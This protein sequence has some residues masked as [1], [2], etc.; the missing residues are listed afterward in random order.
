MPDPSRTLEVLV[1]DDNPGDVKLIREGLKRSSIKLPL[2]IQIA[3]DGEQAL[4]L[5][6]RDNYQPDMIL[7]DLNLPKIDGQTV[8]QRVR[9]EGV[10]LVSTPIVV[11][12]SKQHGIQEVLDAGATSYIVKP[13][14]LTDYL[15]AIEKVA[16]LWLQPLSK[17]A[18]SRD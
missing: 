16:I 11:F 15:K 5:L 2:N 17:S 1:V 6:I 12:S 8:I 14:G 18:D 3:E 10:N 7:I 13:A 9:A 4:N